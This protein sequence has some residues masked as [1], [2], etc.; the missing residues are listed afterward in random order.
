M[1][2]R[3]SSM[4]AGIFAGS[5]AI[6]SLLAIPLDVSAET[7]RLIDGTTVAG[8]VLS[9]NTD[10][11][12]LRQGL[13]QRKIAKSR[14]VHP[15][16]GAL[17]DAQAAFDRKDY[18]VACDL[19]RQIL[20]WEPSNVEAAVLWRGAHQQYV[21]DMLE[22]TRID[23]FSGLG[24]RPLLEIV[25][26]NDLPIVHDI[27]SSC[28]GMQNDWS[29]AFLL[30]W[31]KSEE[32]VEPLL[33][34]LKTWP[35]G[36]GRV[37][38]AY[39]LGEIG[40][41]KAASAL[42]TALMSDQDPG[43]RRR[44]G[45]ALNKLTPCLTLALQKAAQTDKDAGV[46]EE[47]AYLLGNPGYKRTST[48]SLR[49]GDVSAGYLGGTGYTV[50]VPSSYNP[51]VQTHLLIS[52]HGTDGSAAA[53]EAVCHADAERYGL[54]LLAPQFEQGQYPN[55]G[56]FNIGLRTLRPDLKLLKIVDH[57]AEYLNFPKDKLL[58]FGHSQGGQFVHRFVAAHPERI[59][60]AAPCAAN[61]LVMPD[62]AQAFP[63]GMAHTDWT[64]DLADLDIPKY[65]QVPTGLVCG[66]KDAQF[67]QDAARRFVEAASAYADKHEF[68][69]NAKYIPVQDGPHW[70]AS[71]WP[72]ARDF[73]FAELSK[74]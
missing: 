51:R 63:F 1:R 21:R 36:W 5:L 31:L 14:I 68:R 52:V 2:Q 34:A 58:I 4:V 30:G 16:A 8:R 32:S 45:E 35:P 69:C 72:S 24:M 64:P 44:A 46:R 27:M 29:C 26:T 10:Q 73:L 3:H 20:I 42:V 6:V 55:Y 18:P 41:N 40:S 60:R 71:N 74:R 39:A 38:A 15:D 9:A 61:D 48:P 66:T 43:V 65:L 59:W 22:R 33:H 37:Y 28:R 49:P 13:A 54:I 7:I 12:V 47:M 11:V 62:P 53:Y 50:Y 19:S 67:R 56:L 23:P 70:G 17:K 25:S 57:L